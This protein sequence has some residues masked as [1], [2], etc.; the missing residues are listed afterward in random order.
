MKAEVTQQRSLLEM[1]KLDAELSRIAHRATHLP[2]REAYERIKAEHGAA[3]DRVAT[4]RIA[5]EDLDAQVSR[6]ES[7]IEAVQQLAWVGIPPSP[8]LDKAAHA[9]QGTQHEARRHRIESRVDP[10]DWL[11]G[12]AA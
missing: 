4:V 8:A 5:V 7:E 10:R 6:F 2:Q 9:N 3:S 11:R 1:S 12:R